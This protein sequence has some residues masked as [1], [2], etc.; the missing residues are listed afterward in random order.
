[1]RQFTL[2]LDSEYQRP[3]VELKSWHFVEAMLD[4]GAVIPIWTKSERVLSFG[5]ERFIQ[6]M[7]YLAV[8]AVRL[9]LM[10]QR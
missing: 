7:L 1:M 8:L 2:N 4:T 5:A 9:I 3:L 10:M 6:K